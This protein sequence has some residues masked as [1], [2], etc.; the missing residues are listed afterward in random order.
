MARRVLNYCILD[1]TWL[2]HTLHELIA[3][4]V[5]CTR[6]VQDEDSPKLQP[7]DGTGSQGPKFN[8]SAWAVSDCQCEE[9]LFFVGLTIGL[10]PIPQKDDF[11]YIY[12]RA[13]LIGFGALKYRS[14]L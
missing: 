11:P 9:L 3:A 2:M 12:A 10:Y 5:I 1:K 7:G 4:R 14:I 8:C 13:I 6:P